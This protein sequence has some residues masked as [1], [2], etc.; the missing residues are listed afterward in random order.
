MIVLIHVAANMASLNQYS[1]IKQV[2]D[3]V[4]GKIENY[5][6]KRLSQECTSAKQPIKYFQ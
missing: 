6:N 5:I 3:K 4:D 1:L 2:N